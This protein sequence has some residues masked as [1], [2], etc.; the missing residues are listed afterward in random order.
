[1]KTIDGVV[2]MDFSDQFMPMPI[3]SYTG[4][5][6]EEET[7]YIELDLFDAIENTKF[8]VF[9]EKVKF[10][11]HRSC[12]LLAAKKFPEETFEVFGNKIC[13]K[14]EVEVP[15]PP[16]YELPLSKWFKVIDHPSQYISDQTEHGTYLF[17]FTLSR[18]DECD[19]KKY[20]L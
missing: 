13:G 4:L 15:A 17:E 1:M 19:T 18:K 14:F 7:L 5:D 9:S 6:E 8:K 10:E 2:G 20:E 16:C 11:G 12:E 3:T